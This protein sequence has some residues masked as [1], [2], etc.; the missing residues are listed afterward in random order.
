MIEELFDYLKQHYKIQTILDGDVKSQYGFS[1]GLKGKVYTVIFH[2]SM[3][4]TIKPIVFR[5]DF[6]GL[7]HEFNTRN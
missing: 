4:N 1:F 3:V 6:L 7:I 5:T 2:E